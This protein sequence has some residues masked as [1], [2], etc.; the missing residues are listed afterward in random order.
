MIRQEKRNYKYEICDKHFLVTEYLS[1]HFA[2]VHEEK[3]PNK[4]I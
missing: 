2:R 3:K 4:S 1:R